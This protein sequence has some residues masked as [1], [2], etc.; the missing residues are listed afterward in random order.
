MQVSYNAVVYAEEQNKYLVVRAKL[1]AI[2]N[3]IDDDDEHR[4]YF[5]EKQDFY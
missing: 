1:S 5:Q 2:A 3:L 4:G